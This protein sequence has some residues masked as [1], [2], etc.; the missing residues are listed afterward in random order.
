MKT[1]AANTIESMNQT[2][3]EQMEI[4]IE[5]GA[6]FN[7]ALIGGCGDIIVHVKKDAIYSPFLFSNK[8]DVQKTKLQ[9]NL[10]EQGAEVDLKGLLIAN[11]K[12]TITSDVI[13][14]HI[15]EHT[16]S[17]QYVKTMANDEAIIT[18]DATVRIERHAA[19]SS[20]HQLAKNLL[21][22]STAQIQTEPKLEIDNDDVQASH[23][24]SVGS[25]DQQA[26]FYL[27]ARGIA[28]SEARK[29][30]TKA[31]IDEMLNEVK[32]KTI[33]DAINYE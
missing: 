13:I 14:S 23:G 6:R 19:H 7:H 27:Q 12:Q 21:L 3:S 10:A 30:L 1:I 5:A 2:K 22:T 20:A 8:E 24:T 25:L 33:L 29:L 26:L 4:T 17:N 15:A 28:Q 18:A 9:I 11:E 32:D 31:F 16:N